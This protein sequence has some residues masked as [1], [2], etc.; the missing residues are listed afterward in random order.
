MASTNT[1]PL[2]SAFFIHEDFKPISLP[3]SQWFNDIFLTTGAGGTGA[4]THVSLKLTANSN[5]IQL[6]SDG[7]T[8]TLT[9][10][11]TAARTVTFPDAT[12]TLVGRATTDTL[13]NKTF[14]ADGTGNSISN[15]DLTEDITGTLPVA[16]GGTGAT[17]LTDGGLLLGSGTD[18]ITALGVATNGQIPIGDGTTD[19]VLATISEGNGIDITNGAGTITVAGE[20]A[21]DTNAGVVEL[22]TIAETNTGTST[23]LAVTPDGLDGWTG[24][25]QITTLGTIATGTWEGTTIAVDQGGSGQTS[26]TNGQL[27]I[28]NTT[29][30]TL[31][32]ATLSEGEGI[33]ITNG[34]GSITIAGED[35]T[36]LNKGIASFNTSNFSVTSGDVTIKSGGVD[37]TDEV[38]G[39][40]PV[41][42]GGTG[43]TTLTDGGL[44][45]GSGT[46]AITAL[47][48]ATN[49]Q[50]PIGDGTTDPVLATI[51]GG[52]NLSVSNGAG[53]I[54]LNVDDAF[55]ANDGDTGTGVY[56]FG[57]ATSFEIPNSAT[58][59]VD[60]A[61]EIAVDTTITDYTGLIKYHDGTEE[62]TVVAM[63]TGN[64]TTTDTHAVVYDATNNEFKMAAQ[65][66]AS[67]GIVLQIVEAENTTSASTTTTIPFD[68]TIPQNTEG[69][70]IE[71]VSITPSDTA[72]KLLIEGS[73][74][75]TD[76]SAENV[77]TLALFQDST[78]DALAVITQ[79]NN[80]TGFPQ[81]IHIR[82]YMDAGTTSSTTFKLR[83]GP[84]SGT[85]YA[86]R[87]PGGTDIFSTIPKVR[88]LVTE[89]DV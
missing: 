42:N 30:N 79:T 48:V 12:D 14:D 1:P 49:G 28:G 86:L 53:S 43:A 10:S 32:K 22:A 82:H 54:T 59:T 46:A 34:T 41:A 17:T 8:T 18:A 15:V 24:S 40:L 89:I 23:T 75:V 65:S 26:Y 76:M 72:H 71:T 11:A 33:D 73:I 60:A 87:T 39:T 47:G 5:Q 20:A 50:I 70:E 3:W 78:A 6:D 55:L 77:F 25:A 45:I 2:Q 38:T 64:L 16:N 35:A 7:T 21:S 13:T 83:Y 19:P 62:L 81:S 37:L 69:A 68:A 67:G 27:L 63:P 57:G 58:P 4:V 52:T 66:G 88:L 44:L 85:A 51:T 31:T 61:G 9:D 36:S 56:D 84:N 74:D 80:S 29:G